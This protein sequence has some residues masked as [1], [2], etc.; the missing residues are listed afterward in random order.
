MK[1]KNFSDFGVFQKLKYLKNGKASHRC[2]NSNDFE[3]VQKYK[4]S[5][6]CGATQ[7]CKN[8]KL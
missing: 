6:D 3:V 4:N 8:S 7:N 5:F 1:S 2:K